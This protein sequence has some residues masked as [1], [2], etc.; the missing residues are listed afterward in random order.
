MNPYAYVNNSPVNLR[1]PEGLNECEQALRDQKGPDGKRV[2]TSEEMIKAICGTG[3]MSLP[4]VGGS[5]WR[6]GS[7]E[8]GASR[9][10]GNRNYG[11]GAFAN[12]AATAV[13]GFGD[14]ASFGVTIAIRGV[15]G[16]NE[17]VSFDSPAYL[18]GAVIGAFAG[19]FLQRKGA[20][21]KLGKDF[22]LAPYGNRTDHP[23]G[24]YPHYHRRIK[25]EFGNTVP[26]GGIGRH[27]PYDPPAP[28]TPWYRRF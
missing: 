19:A 9:M 15:I 12:T 14:G 21:L 20:E 5:G 13:V 17:N 27:R 16:G 4:G 18:R 1:D 23:T 6:F 25:D 10:F 8:S 24:R 2:H 3:A 28:G 7:R 11:I 22:R 26:G